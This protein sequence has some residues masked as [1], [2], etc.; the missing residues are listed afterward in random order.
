MTQSVQ[1]N[2][3]AGAYPVTQRAVAA[4]AAAAA[5]AAPAAAISALQAMLPAPATTNG[6]L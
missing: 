3:E 5:A 2:Y 4:A 1:H 6:A